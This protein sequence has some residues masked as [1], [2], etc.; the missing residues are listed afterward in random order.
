[1]SNSMDR[2][3]RTGRY[4]H[5]ILE[6][7]D[8]EEVIEWVQE[9][10]TYHQQ[11]GHNAITLVKGPSLRVVLLAMQEGGRL[12]R[13][14]APGPITIQVLR[15]RIN[16]SLVTDDTSTTIEVNQG[17]LMVLEEQKL[18]EVVALEESALLL[19]IVNL[20]SDGVEK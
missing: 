11:N 6:S 8:L 14:H 15:G 17:Q 18:H 9:E 1:M 3:D 19:T 16:F 13:H 7:F 12:H 5:G 2:P 10:E 4:L 20:K